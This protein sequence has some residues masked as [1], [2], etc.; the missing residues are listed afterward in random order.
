MH[1]GYLRYSNKSGFFSHGFIIFWIGPDVL[2]FRPN[3]LCRSSCPRP[4]RQGS[5]PAPSIKPLCA[6]WHLD[7]WHYGFRRVPQPSSRG[8][9]SAPH[10]SDLPQDL[11]GPHTH[12]SSSLPT[13]SEP[14]KARLDLSW[15]RRDSM[16]EW[17]A[18]VWTPLEAILTSFIYDIIN[19]LQFVNVSCVCCQNSFHLRAFLV[20]SWE[21]PNVMSSFP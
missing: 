15:T 18:G 17:A 3:L 5:W 10:S 4:C 14:N 20:G 19:T 8:R 16:K 21:Q 11:W 2:C 12:P 7:L 13:S 1:I 9:W 6:R